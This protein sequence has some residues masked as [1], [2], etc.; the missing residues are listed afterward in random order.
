MFK[1][2]NSEMRV[3][4][5]NKSHL[6]LV[7]ILAASLLAIGIPFVASAEASE[8][9]PTKAPEHREVYFPNTEDLDPNEMRVIACGTGMPTTRAAQA[10]ACFLVELGNGDKFVFDAGSGSA[11]RISSLQIPYS[12]L[13]KIFLSHLHGDHFGALGEMFIGGALMGRQVPLRVWGA[14]GQVE[15]LGTKHALEGMEQM[16]KWD[17]AGRIG[18]V[19][20]RGFKLEANEFDYRGEN[21]IVYDD[22]G[23]VIRSWPAIHAIDG[24]VS[25]SLEWNGLKFVYGGDTYP[26]KWF[27]EYA[28][29]ADLAIHECFVAVPDLV[30]KMRFTPEQALLVGT[31]VHTA[32]EAF[33]K[34]MSE[35][36]PRMAVAYH[37]FKDFDTTGQVNDRIRTTYDGPLSLAEDFMVWNITKDD[38][39]VRMAVV[40]EATWAPPL[41][42]KAALPGEDDQKIY[43]EAS[44][45]PVENMTNSDFISSQRW[46]GVDEALRGVYK[47]A[48]EAL[49]QEFPYPGDQ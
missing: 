27:N 36:K 42:G 43:S 37:F 21:E 34:I 28:K 46:D 44:G 12:Y 18:L 13:D 9:S 47:E 5:P 24:P 38:I 35:I 6:G 31:Q 29:D 14:T 33:G 3:G 40:E 30:A 19:D 45:V 2:N 16:Y 39:R 20:A 22:N 8:V 11:E 1:V 15:E 41:A 25:F 48:E 17:L 7:S 4:T 32:P 23:V 26:N 10:A 49:G